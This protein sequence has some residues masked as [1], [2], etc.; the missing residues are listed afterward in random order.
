MNCK[1][2]MYGGGPTFGKL[3]VEE[4]TGAIPARA[5]RT[6]KRVCVVLPLRPAVRITPAPH[7]DRTRQPHPT[8]PRPS[9]PRF[10]SAS[11]PSASA[12]S[13]SAPSASLL[14]SAPQ[15]YAAENP[16]QAAYNHLSLKVGGVGRG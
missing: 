6:S 15:R 1:C 2:E 7:D 14:T 11:A 16:S 4:R 13:A 12:P 5:H 10:P 8:L 9:D 3:T